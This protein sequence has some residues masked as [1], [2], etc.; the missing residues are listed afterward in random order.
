MLAE[1]IEIIR[2]LWEGDLFSFDGTHYTVDERRIYTLPEE[3]GRRSS[4]RRVARRRRRSP[5]E[6]G[7]G[8]I[9]TAPETELVDA[10]RR[11]RRRAAPATGSSPSAGQRARREAR[12]TA[13]EWWPNA[14]LKGP[15][16]Q[17]LPLPSHF[18]A[19]SAMV[20]EDE[21]AEHIL[22]GPDPD[23]APREIQAFADAG[24]DHVY[25]HQIGPDQAGFLDAYADGFLAEA[26][27]LEARRTAETTA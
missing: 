24:F 3:R 16:S 27:V 9:S 26:R 12:R 17:E 4:S 10:F 20:T 11:C 2:G 7:D 15:L 6:I 22:C 25:I 13:L 5:G 8:L 19:A 1:A 21:I 23:R 18:E 14:G